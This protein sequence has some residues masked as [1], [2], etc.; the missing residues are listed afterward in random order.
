[1]NVKRELR[2]RKIRPSKF[3]DQYFIRDEN[4]FRREAEYAKINKGDVVL[5]IGAGFGNR[6]KFLSDKVK[7]IIAIEKDPH[8]CRIIEKLGLDNVEIIRGNALEIDFPNFNKIIS[9]LPFGISSPITFKLMDYDWNMAVLYYQKS[10]AERLVARPGDKNYSRLSLAV[11]YYAKP[12]ILEILPKELFYPSPKVDCALVRL[13]EKKPEDVGDFFWTV[14]KSCFR[15]KGKKV[16]NALIDM[17]DIDT[18]KIRKIK[19]PLFQKKVLDCSQEDFRKISNI[20]KQ[21]YKN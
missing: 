7:K 9:N 12:E 10:F 13:R 15:H 21:N 17:E 4:I 2:K 1:M 8:L 16:K 20:L 5:E 6:I 18:E 11:Q 14:V 19:N 3:N